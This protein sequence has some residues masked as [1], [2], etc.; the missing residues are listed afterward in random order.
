MENDVDE[1][2][3]EEMEIEPPLR[4][5][6]QLRR[7]TSSNTLPF[8]AIGPEQIIGCDRYQLCV[9][10]FGDHVLIRLASVETHACEMS[11]GILPVDESLKTGGLSTFRG[12][13][14]KVAFATQ[15]H[16]ALDGKTWYKFIYPIETQATIVPVL[17]FQ[18]AQIRDNML[19]S[20]IR[21]A[22]DAYDESQTALL[23][24]TEKEC[25]K[26][27]STTKRLRDDTLALHEKVMR[28]LQEDITY[29]EQLQF[30]PN[31]LKLRQGIEGNLDMRR[32]LMRNITKEIF[33]IQTMLSQ[34]YTTEENV[35]SRFAT[36]LKLAEGL[37]KKR[38]PLDNL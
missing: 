8:D 19:A 20:S 32:M 26:L 9:T 21:S 34:H 22:Y 11:E 38:I 5:K 15:S 13:T 23:A 33:D 7:I 14:K 25:E 16:I 1:I 18:E 6:P 10:A 35:F 27:A 28:D 30:R 24:T 36:S 17:D 29:M 2:S 3:D 12:I 4:L 31:D 37:S